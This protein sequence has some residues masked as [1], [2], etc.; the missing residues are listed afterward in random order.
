MSVIHSI[1]EISEKLKGTYNKGRIVLL[2]N[3]D[4]SI[5]YPTWQPY[6]F[7][8]QVEI[9][10][11]NERLLNY[12]CNILKNNNIKK[13]KCCTIQEYSQVVRTENIFEFLKEESEEKILKWINNDAFWVWPISSKIRMRLH[14]CV[15]FVCFSVSDYDTLGRNNFIFID[16]NDVNFDFLEINEEMLDEVILK[17][18]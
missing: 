3:D 17:L 12:L 7:H 8:K 9:E 10:I 4:V 6:Y 13:F 16:I 2:N 18:I 14:V 1:L 11:K 15:R 5:I